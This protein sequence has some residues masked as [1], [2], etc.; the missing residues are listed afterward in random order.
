MS[1]PI[2]VLVEVKRNEV[3]IQELAVTPEGL[4]LDSWSPFELL[5]TVRQIKVPGA[6]GSLTVWRW[7]SEGESGDES[8]KRGAVAAMLADAGYVEVKLTATMPDLLAE[9][10]AG[11]S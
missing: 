1:D 8:T 6:R 10:D 2:S 3:H 7:E 9:L 5:G 4:A 11:A